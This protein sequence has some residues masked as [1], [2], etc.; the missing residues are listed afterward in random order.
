MTVIPNHYAR[1]GSAWIRGVILVA[2]TLAAVPLA[3]AEDAA[4]WL[5]RA[6]AAAQ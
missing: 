4:A 1:P 6:A 2:V 3:L 5:S